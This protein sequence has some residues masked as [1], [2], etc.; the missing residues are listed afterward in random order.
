[1]FNGLIVN[2]TGNDLRICGIENAIREADGAELPEE[3]ADLFDV[4][5]VEVNGERRLVVNMLDD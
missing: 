2:N 3:I 5:A 4:E 1:M